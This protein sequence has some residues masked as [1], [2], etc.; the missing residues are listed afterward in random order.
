MFRTLL[1]VGALAGLTG[2]LA[3]AFHA[4]RLSGAPSLTLAAQP[5]GMGQPTPEQIRA[6]IQQGAAKAP[7][8]EH[9]QGLVGEWDATISFLSAPGAQPD[10]SKMTASITPILDGRYVLS[11]YT[12]SFKYM[13]AEIPF[14]GYGMVGYDKVRGH[15]TSAWGDNMST[16]MLVQTGPFK[17]GAIDLKGEMPDGMGG[18]M[19]M[20]HRH[21]VNDDGSYTLEFH[22][23]NPATGEMVK[24]GWIDHAKR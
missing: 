7:E 14:E 23:P 22:Q 6:M 8:H 2:A 18:A 11:H 15:F 1:S 16:S 3:L 24:I 10:V 4:G 19:P 20:R 9:L 21:V 5:E 13:G 17:E 12:G